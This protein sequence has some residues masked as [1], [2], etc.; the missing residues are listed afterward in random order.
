MNFWLNKFFFSKEKERERNRIFV[1]EGNFVA[2]LNIILIFLLKNILGPKI[3]DYSKK[4]CFVLYFCNSGDASSV[5]ELKK[6]FLEIK[7]TFL[8]QCLGNETSRE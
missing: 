4:Y 8:E 2:E 5:V 3:K 1:L 6:K 7:D